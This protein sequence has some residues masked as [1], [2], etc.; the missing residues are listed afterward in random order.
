MPT[1][2]TRPAG[3]RFLRASYITFAGWARVIIAPGP[4]TDPDVRV[5][6]SGSSSHGFAAQWPSPKRLIG[7]GRGKR[8]SRC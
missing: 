7:L 8:P 4:P 6:A 5:A 2:T 3:E 1:M